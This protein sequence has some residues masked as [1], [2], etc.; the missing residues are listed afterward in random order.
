MHTEFTPQQIREILS[1]LF[2]KYSFVRAFVES[3]AGEVLTVNNKQVRAE[4][5]ER[6]RGITISILHRGVFYEA[7]S[8]LTTKRDIEKLVKGLSESI[9][10][11]RYAGNT[12]ALSEQ[13]EIEKHFESKQGEDYSFERKIKTAKEI[14]KQLEELDDRITLAQVRYKRLLQEEMYISEKKTLSQKISR[15][16]AIFIAVLSDKGH[17]AQIYDGYAMHGGWENMVPPE[18]MLKN[19]IA[20]G[21]KIL[22]A[23]RL[24]PG[25]YDCIFDPS[26]AGILAHEAFGH[27]TEGDTMAKGRAK[28]TQYLGKEV[29][30]PLVKLYDNPALENVAASYFFDH[31]GQLASETRIVENGILQKPMTDFRSANVLNVSRT[32]NGRREAYDHK[33]YTRMS[34]TYF[35]AGNDKLEEMIQS[36]DDGFLVSRATNGMEDPLG[37]GIQLE[38]LMAT[39]IKDGK[40]TDEVYSPVIVT[41]YVPD[42][43][44]SISM[45]SD[46]MEING[47]G[48]CGKGHKEW[49]KVTDG[50]PYLK[51]RVRLA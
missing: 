50:G 48:M 46:T 16:E 29:A 3:S 8:P 45:V 32:A 34:N 43:L 14:L 41:G 35:C 30:S 25:I 21:V 47:L 4:P 39:R 20:D 28:G 40:L 22:Y 1:P 7:S 17:S 31:E 15:F 2:K 18:K 12:P 24:D 9:E 49:V 13:E 37:W 11:Y 23:K 36:I 6:K 38:A 10:K 33:V 27:G 44:K 42:I 51:L 5:V 26:M 19:M